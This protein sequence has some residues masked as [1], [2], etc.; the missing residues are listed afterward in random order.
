MA[1][2]YRGELGKAVPVSFDRIVPAGSPAAQALF[3]DPVVGRVR[4]RVLVQEVAQD[5]GPALVDAEAAARCGVGAP[6]V[7]IAE[8][9]YGFHAHLTSPGR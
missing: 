4:R 6:G 5:P 7:G 2:R 8:A 9:K 1:F 3:H